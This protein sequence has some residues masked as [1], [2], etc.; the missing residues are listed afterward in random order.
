VVNQYIWIGIVVGVFITGIGIGYAAFQLYDQSNFANMTPQQ[1]QQM[2]NNPQFMNQWMSNMMQNQNFQQQYMGPWMM[3]KDPQFM[4]N[5]RNQ[6]MQQYQNQ[7]PIMTNEV[8][9]ARDSW[10]Y[11]F[12]NGFSP[13]VIQVSSGSTVT[14]KNNDEV[15][16]TVTHFGNEF[17]SG[18]IPSGSNWQHTFGSTGNYDYFCS[19]HPWMKGIVIVS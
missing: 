11:Q 19:I 1:M 5:M 15:I 18:F 3:M 13:A 4:Q 6:W 8:S 10:E 2:M 12:L 9:I 16:H 14:W 17:D 7:P